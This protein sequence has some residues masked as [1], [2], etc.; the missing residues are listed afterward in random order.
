MHAL[1]VVLSQSGYD[2]ATKL[3]RQTSSR[4]LLCN[5]GIATEMHAAIVA[6][7]SKEHFDNSNSVEGVNAILNRGVSDEEESFLTLA[8]HLVE[9]VRAVPPILDIHSV[10]L[11]PI[12]HLLV[13]AWSARTRTSFELFPKRPV[14]T[15]ADQLSAAGNLT[16]DEAQIVK[17]KKEAT[18]TAI[19][20]YFILSTSIALSLPYLIS[21]TSLSPAPLVENDIG[22]ILDYFFR[23]GSTSSPIISRL[24]W[25]CCLTD[26][27]VSELVIPCVKLL[28]SRVRTERRY[29]D[30]K[31]ARATRH[32]SVVQYEG[33]D[34]SIISNTS[35]YRL[36][37]LC[38][39]ILSPSGD[40]YWTNLSGC[41]QSDL[42]F[43]RLSVTLHTYALHRQVASAPTFSVPVLTCSPLLHPRRRV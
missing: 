23:L 17:R 13:K 19:A 32:D 11:S 7:E 3:I 39:K 42:S 10:L 21:P 28:L 6:L 30:S 15:V 29:Q 5:T 22:S 36:T 16:I 24:D 25:M 4:L 33:A 38:E 35:A 26:R 18:P 31:D 40:G 34:H 41:S 9:Y 2:D 43:V 8:V 20:K 27:A 37:P 1:C 14:V 12:L